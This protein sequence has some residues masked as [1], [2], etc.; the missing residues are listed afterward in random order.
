VDLLDLKVKLEQLALLGRVAREGQVDLRGSEVNPV[1]L[2]MLETLDHPGCQGHLDLVALLVLR[3]QWEVQGLLDLEERLDRQVLEELL[4]HLDHLGRWERQVLLDQQDHKVLKGLVD[5]MDKMGLLEPLVNWAHLVLLAHLAL[6][7]L[8][9]QEA[10]PERQDLQGPLVLLD[11]VAVLDPLD[12]LEVLE[13]PD[14]LD[15]QGHL[16][17]GVNQVPLDHQATLVLLGQLGLQVL[18]GHLVNVDLVVK[19]DSQVQLDPL[20]NEDQQDLLDHQD[21]LV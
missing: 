6:E 12:L 19:E 16:V 20:E 5:L 14:L 21:P 11:P 7:D 13:K 1:S 3:G 9:V 18:L 15:Q 10:H 8:L 2:A 4:D 17:Q